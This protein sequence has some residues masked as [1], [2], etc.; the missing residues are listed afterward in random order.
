ML[1]ILIV[2]SALTISFLGG[3]VQKNSLWTAWDS[4]HILYILFSYSRYILFSHYVTRDLNSRPTY[5][6]A[7]GV[8]NRDYSRTILYSNPFSRVIWSYEFLVIH[9]FTVEDC[10][11]FIPFEHNT[12]RSKDW[13][14][15]IIARIDWFRRELLL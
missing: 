8:V 14:I 5:L 9:T 12:V 15:L 6:F 3:S 1:R 11:T 4:R 13:S 10:F 7:G 2:E